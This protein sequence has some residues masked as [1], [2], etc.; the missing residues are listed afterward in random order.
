MKPERQNHEPKIHHEPGK[1][2][3]YVIHLSHNEPIISKPSSSPNL[4]QLA[5]QLVLDV[6]QDDIEEEQDDLLLDFDD[7]VH[8]L[9]ETDYNEDTETVL[10]D[11]PKENEIPKIDEPTQIRSTQ[12]SPEK[13]ETEFL[14]PKGTDEEETISF[15]KKI[16]RFELPNIPS[17]PVRGMKVKT[18]AAFVALSFAFVLPLHAVQ[19]VNASRSVESKITESGAQAI[20]HFMQG[21]DAL[22]RERFS[23]AEMDFTRAHEDFSAAENSLHEVNIA[24]STLAQVL[25]KTNDAYDSAKGLLTAGKEFSTAA[26]ILADAVEN[27]QSQ[28]SLTAT[29]KID[30]LQTY[31]AS[32]LP[33]IASATHAMEQVDPEAVPEE[34]RETVAQLKEKS[35]SL[36]QSLEEFNEFSTALT[37]IMGGERKMRYLVVFQNNTELRATGGFPGSFAEIDVMNGEITD[38]HIPPGGTYDVQGQLSAFVEAPKPIALINPRWE[39]HDA[40]WFPDFPT[41]A[42]KTLWFYEKAGGTTMDGVIAINATIMPKLLEVTGPIE[43]PEYGRTIDA[44]NFLFE[45]QKIVEFEYEEYQGEGTDRPEDA[46][47]QF[48]GAL[49]PKVLEKLMDAD[50]DTTL[51]MLDVLG[52]GLQEKDTLIYLEDNALQSEVQQLGWAGEQK[53]T[54][55]D[56]LMVVNTNLGGGKTDTVID[57]TID[58]YSEISADGSIVNTVTITKEHKGLQTALFEG[59]NNV[60]YI[61]LYVPKGSELISAEGFEIPPDELFEPSEVALTKDEDIA[62]LESDRHID[63]ISQTDIWNENG[64]TVFG[65]WIQTKPGEIEQVTF[66]YRIPITLTSQK[67]EITLFDKLKEKLGVKDLE[68]HT[69]FI[70]KQPGVE[71]R[72][73]NVTVSLPEKKPI[74]WSSHTGESKGK[75][76]HITNTH[77]QFIRFLL[78]NEL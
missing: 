16:S 42:Q 13:L 57:Q 48:I 53:Q 8:Q 45:T 34:Y 14:Q 26:S 2:S 17:T 61:R 18:I 58:L 11:E 50:M 64:K 78:Q 35:P 44:E 72:A 4:D 31:I 23:V 3:P 47:K 6:E 21:A 60:D 52:Q 70:Q 36:Y 65:N 76:I 37:T 74:I 40:N 71:T 32:A 62:L 75:D 1:T 66:T 77:D 63:P 9:K 24:L 27:L 49:A 59:V 30:L 43:M 54:D 39:F 12:I 15:F 20:S 29:T 10:I 38:I 69:I 56:Y 73:T 25:P 55:G 19:Q 68:T 67:T 5:K 22:G 41:S 7:I 51:A 33:H 46:P 28:E